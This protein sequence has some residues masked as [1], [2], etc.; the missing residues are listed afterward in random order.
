MVKFMNPSFNSPANN[1][2]YNDNYER[3]FGKPCTNEECKEKAYYGYS[4][5]AKHLEE[6]GITPEQP[7][8][9]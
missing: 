6:S 7:E 4:L 3:T 9:D 5:C 8:S 1:S 2:N